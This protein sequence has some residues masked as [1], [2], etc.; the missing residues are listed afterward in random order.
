MFQTADNLLSPKRQDPLLVSASN[1]C[2]ISITSFPGST[3]VQASL[4]VGVSCI[5][6]PVI[7]AKNH[8]APLHQIAGI[9]AC[10]TICRKGAMNREGK[11]MFPSKNFTVALRDIDR[12][13]TTL[14]IALA[15]FHE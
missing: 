8:E 11:G 12:E 3:G 5:S 4:Y 13:V 9:C 10:K 15:F 14:F 6:K 2:G 1:P 7:P